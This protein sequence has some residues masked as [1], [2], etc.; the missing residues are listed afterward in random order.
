MY[1]KDFSS[2]LEF[3]HGV[4]RT[5]LLKANYFVVKFVMW[6]KGLFCAIYSYLNNP[7]KRLT[8]I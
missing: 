6:K 8:E 2:F 3:L 1:S 4:Q 5:K 7:N